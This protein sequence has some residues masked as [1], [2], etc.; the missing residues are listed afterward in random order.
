MKDGMKTLKPAQIVESN[1]RKKANR[2][3]FVMPQK[4][5]VTCTLQTQYEM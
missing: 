3:L 4:R 5:Q 1:G 2:A